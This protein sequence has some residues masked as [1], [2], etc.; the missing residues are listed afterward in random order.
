MPNV[1]ESPQITSFDRLGL[2]LFLAISIHAMFVLGVSF[3]REDDPL[4]P[5]APPMEITLVHPIDPVKVKDAKLLAQVGQE[6]GGNDSREGRVA[7]QSMAQPVSQGHEAASSRAEQR[8]EQSHRE[9][10]MMMT[11]SNPEA[12]EIKSDPR[13]EQ[14]VTVAEAEE[15]LQ[16][17][18]QEIA[19]LSA[20]INRSLEAYAKRDRHRYLAARTKSFR[21]ALYLEAWQEKIEQIGNLNYPNEAKRRHLTGDLILDVAIIPDGSLDS[22]TIRHSSGKKILDDAAIRIVRLAA[23]FAPF[24]KDMRRDTDVLHIIRTWRF[25]NGDR[26]RAD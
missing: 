24:S 19:R 12:E 20:E 25:M 11:T 14:P 3:T 5:P 13:K 10:D 2:T 7:S 16:K 22:V 26:L 9:A 23:P 6:G 21:D 1:A 4:Q 8:P 18:Q 15:T 17:Q